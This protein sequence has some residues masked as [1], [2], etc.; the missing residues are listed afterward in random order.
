[1]HSNFVIRLCIGDYP[2]LS[3]R[4]APEKPISWFNSTGC[5]NSPPDEIRLSPIFISSH[6]ISMAARLGT[7]WAIITWMICIEFAFMTLA[8]RSL[9]LTDNLI[10]V[11]VKWSLARA[12]CVIDKSLITFI[13]T[14]LHLW[15]SDWYNDGVMVDQLRCWFM[16]F[17][18]IQKSKSV[19][20][21]SE[22]LSRSSLF[23]G[24]KS[25]RFIHFQH[26][27]ADLASTSCES[28]GRLKFNSNQTWSHSASKHSPFIC[29]AMQHV[30]CVC[31]C[32]LSIRAGIRLIGQRRHICLE[33][34]IKSNQMWCHQRHIEQV[35]QLETE[36]D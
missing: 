12:L 11:E 26:P 35:N 16:I 22:S 10:R 34:Q 13:K 29:R 2:S 24:G 8:A 6:L 5:L 32:V 21:V 14:W 4:A 28:R 1:M 25:E 7:E 9:I 18:K 27:G 36:Q 17:E 20:N 30:L 33:N 23:T 19:W 31:V 3:S 15:L